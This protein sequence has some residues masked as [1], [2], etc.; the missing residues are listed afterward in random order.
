[1]TEKSQS[2]HQV[3]DMVYR[4]AKAPPSSPHDSNYNE[5]EWC[6]CSRCREIPVAEERL[7]CRRVNG[8]RVTE[9]GEYDIIY[10]MRL[11]ISSNR[12]DLFDLNNEPSNNKLGHTA[13]R[14][15]VLCDIQNLFSIRFDT[16]L[17]L[18]FDIRYDIR[19]CY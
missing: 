5:Q 3:Y 9:Q 15:L 10:S 6:K 13:Y 11:W 7:C 17:N 16:I 18:N 12:N 2:S 4:M 8:P 14:Q 1:M 19:Y